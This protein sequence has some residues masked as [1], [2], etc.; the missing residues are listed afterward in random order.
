MALNLKR[1][2]PSLLGGISRRRSL[3]SLAGSLPVTTLLQCPPRAPPLRHMSSASPR[4]P[5]SN[6]R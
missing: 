6:D 3:N 1:T 4:I 5:P 2:N